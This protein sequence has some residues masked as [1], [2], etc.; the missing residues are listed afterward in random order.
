MLC[1]FVC[2][3]VCVVR[4]SA[5]WVTTAGFSFA[6]TLDFH[7]EVCKIGHMFYA[8]V[9]THTCGCVTQTHAHTH[10]ERGNR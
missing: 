4:F 6:N 8:L 3:S 7:A 1:M 10:P 5:L 2:V 9:I